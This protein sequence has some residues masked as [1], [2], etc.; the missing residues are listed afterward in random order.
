MCICSKSKLSC[1]MPQLWSRCCL[2]V[3]SVYST[4]HWGPACFALSR[5][6]KLGCCPLAKGNLKIDCWCKSNHRLISRRSHWKC[7][8]HH[9]AGKEF[10]FFIFFNA[11][12]WFGLP[13]LDRSVL[14]LIPMEEIGRSPPGMREIWREGAEEYS[15]HQNFLVNKCMAAW[16]LQVSRKISSYPLGLVLIYQVLDTACFTAPGIQLFTVS[17]NSV[18]HFCRTL[19]LLGSSQGKQRK[20]CMIYV[21]PIQWC[22]SVIFLTFLG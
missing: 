13:R 5:V 21:Q 16:E 12:V 10:V 15:P 20:N 6:V 14:L 18:C 11:T 8:I 3:F 2:L 17:K 22:F 19:F 4:G 9:R 1:E 7:L